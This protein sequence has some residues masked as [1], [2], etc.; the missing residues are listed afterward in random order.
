MSRS[1]EDLPGD[2][3]EHILKCKCSC[4]HMGYGNCSV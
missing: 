2:I 4:D 3:R 1:L